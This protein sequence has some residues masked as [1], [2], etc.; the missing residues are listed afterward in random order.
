MGFV[1]A[2][3]GSGGS[4]TPATIAVVVIALLWATAVWA[5]IWVGTDALERSFLLVLLLA[6]AL[7]GGLPFLVPY[8]ISGHGDYL[9]RFLL[10]LLLTTGM[11]LGAALWS[12]R[13]GP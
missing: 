13:F 10:S 5:A 4:N 1:L 6:S 9:G 2:I 11:G 12:R 8:G 7:I 3:C